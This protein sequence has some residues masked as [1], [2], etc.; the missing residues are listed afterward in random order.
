MILLVDSF[1]VPSSPFA[2][3]KPY[4]SDEYCLVRKLNAKTVFRAQPVP[5]QQII[6][7]RLHGDKFIYRIYLT[8]M[9]LA[10][11]H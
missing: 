1:R 9:I 5:N 11:T 8:K 4:G 6:L 10:S 7:S 3:G 2:I